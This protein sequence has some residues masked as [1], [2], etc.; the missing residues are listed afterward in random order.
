MIDIK[1]LRENPEVVEKAMKARNLSVDI[2]A[3]LALDEA[4]RALIQKTEGI[5]AAKNEASKKIPSASPEEKKEILASMKALD[6]NG[7]QLAQDLAK[8]DQDF[9]AALKALPNIPQPDVKQ[10]KDDSENEVIRTVGEPTKFDFPVKDHLELGEKLG[11][12]DMQRAAKVSGTRFVYLIGDGAMLEFALLQ[13]TMQNLVLAGFSP[14]VPPVIIKASSMEAMGFLK[15]GAE[16]DIYH[17]KADDSY[18][19]GTSEQSIGPMYMDEII[20]GEQ[21]PLRYAGFSSCFRRESGAA[22]KDT[23]G[24]LRVHQFDKIEMFSFT[25]PEDSEAEHQKLLAV[26]EK[27]VQGL[28]LPYHVLRQCTGDMGYPSARTFD[29]ETWMPSQNKY[30]ETHSTSTCT[31]YQA[32]RL[33]TRFRGEDGKVNLVHTLNGTAF[34]IGR[35]IIAIMEN[36]Q[37]ADGSIAIPEVLQPFMMGKKEIKAK[38]A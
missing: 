30:R 15:A 12:I 13:Y 29:I 35:I 27:L 3:I 4:R 7:D 19:V 34:A 16:D 32:R 33:N 10:G 11:I 23:R 24:M 28:N 14:V 2:A 26:Q 18:L 38:G 17:L 25:K 6:V 8:A 9:N 1:I 36:N 31:D 22:G 20:P 21:L 5:K 37:R